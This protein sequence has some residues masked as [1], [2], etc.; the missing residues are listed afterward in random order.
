MSLVRTSEELRIL[1]LFWPKPST[2]RE[3]RSR[4]R[5]STGT[6]AE[7]GLIIEHVLAVLSVLPSCGPYRR[8]LASVRCLLYKHD[9]DGGS[10][11][12]RLLQYRTVRRI[13][14]HRTGC[15]PQKSVSNCLPFVVSPSS[16]ADIGDVLCSISTF[17]I[18]TWLPVVVA[19]DGAG[20]LPAKRTCH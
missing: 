9:T 4:S 8:P 15:G 17:E 16:S 12:Y 6:D 18:R 19:G 13:A 10:N 2:H 3:D 20:C 11:S 1:R 14:R 5:H 7:H